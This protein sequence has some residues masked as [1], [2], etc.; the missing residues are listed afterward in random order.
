MP[1]ARLLLSAAL[2]FA[3]HAHAEEAFVNV[4]NW[5]D[6]VAEST[7]ADFTK[8]SGIK[9]VYDV[10][11]S[12]EVL[13]TK[14]LA[15][16]SGYD[17]VFP[18]ARPN[19]E[20]LVKGG[21]LKALDFKQLPNYKHLDRAILAAL[22]DA[23]PGN[24]HLVPY[25][26][27]TTGIGYNVEKVRAALGENASVDSWAVLF[28]PAS[29]AKLKGCGI[30]FLD[31]EIEA[32]AAALIYQGRD[33]NSAKPADIQSVSTLY[34]AIRPSIKY[35]QS[36]QYIN[37]LANGDICIAMGYS[38]DVLQARDRAAE[39]KRGVTIRYLIPR[40]GAVRWIDTAAIPLDAPHPNNAHRF[41]NFLLDP[42]VITAISNTVS[43]A[44]ANSTSK[45]LL[46]KAVGLD[47]GIYPPPPVEAKLRTT[48]VH[49]SAEKR[50]RVR[51]WT[52]IK[53]GK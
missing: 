25:M 36:S 12:N 26:W 39:V 5:S 21:M 33:L 43:Y 49:S 23:D 22:T 16:G 35:F 27:G 1:N 3:L 18:S 41:I 19:G 6:Y 28:D 29:A 10:Y 14:L 42:T 13:E 50:L 48:R 9:V 7:L 2:M 38:G 11:D 30:S 31:D 8:Q 44:N 4:Y 24:A 37:D 52:R 20:R 45:P 46:D 17:V 51:A 32:F 53:T 40:E 47:P 15:G 34:T